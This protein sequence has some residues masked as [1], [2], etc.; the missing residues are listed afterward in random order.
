MI[1]HTANDPAAELREGLRYLDILDDMV[2]SGMR[3]PG[4][5]YGNARSFLEKMLEACLSE[6]DEEDIDVGESGRNDDG[7]GEGGKEEVAERAIN[8]GGKL[9]LETQDAE[10]LDS[11]VRDEA[12]EG[13]ETE[14]DVKEVKSGDNEEEPSEEKLG[15]ANPSTT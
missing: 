12:E 9:E 8:D 1:S 11:K 7:E 2:K 5:W 15:A 13:E 4:P 6:S 10:T 3:T 14:L